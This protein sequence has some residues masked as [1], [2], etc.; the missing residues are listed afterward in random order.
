[1]PAVIKRPAGAKRGKGPAPTTARSGRAGGIVVRG[2]TKCIGCGS[3]APTRY[4]GQ[5]V[6]DECQVDTLARRRTPLQVDNGRPRAGV[7]GGGAPPKPRPHRNGPPAGWASFNDVARRELKRADAAADR[8]YEAALKAP[9][10][11]PPKPPPPP[12]RDVEQRLYADASERRW[13][14]S[15]ARRNAGPKPADVVTA[16]VSRPLRL[17]ERRAGHRNAC[18][19]GST[20]FGTA[21]RF[22][23]DPAA[24]PPAVGIRDCETYTY[25]AAEAGIRDVR[26]ARAAALSAA[27]SAVVYAKCLGDLALRAR[28]DRV[29][30]ERSADAVDMWGATTFALAALFDRL[31]ASRHSTKSA[32]RRCLRIARVSLLRRVWP[33]LLTYEG[34]L[35]WDAASRRA[36]GVPA[37]RA[38]RP[39]RDAPKKPAP[40]PRRI[41]DWILANFELRPTGYRSRSHTSALVRA[42][43]ELKDEARLRRVDELRAKEKAGDTTTLAREE[44]G[45]LVVGA[46]RA[47]ALTVKAPPSC[48]FGP[49]RVVSAPPVRRRAPQ[50]PCPAPLLDIPKRPATPVLDTLD[51]APP[52]AASDDYTDPGDDYME[53]GESPA[54]DEAAAP[55]PPASGAGGGAPDQAAVPLEASPARVEIEAP[56]PGAF[57]S[58]PRFV[59]GAVVEVR[60]CG[61]EDWYPGRVARIAEDGALDIEYEDGDY[62]AAVAPAL[63]RERLGG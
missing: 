38:P 49:P 58:P 32:A 8:A 39:R 60:F 54:S 18:S 43:R 11:P 27:V 62:E 37:M 61:M 10:A 50:K 29:Q 36:Q 26:M 44:G 42:R 22:S 46:R 53:P 34:R 9:P 3:H 23:G 12:P 15:V 45:R 17:R 19:A 63:V 21:S 55:S 57:S 51:V 31:H 7:C 6:C 13:R 40:V 59:V 5:R 48:S 35:A 25:I 56:A 28:D 1:M 24:P 33:R 4:T 52:P 14:K 20:T 41:H 47:E 30:R 2:R 16:A